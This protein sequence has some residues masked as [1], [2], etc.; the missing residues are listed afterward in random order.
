MNNCVVKRLLSVFLCA[1]LLAQPLTMSAGAWYW[2]VEDS[3]DR[4]EEVFIQDEAAPLANTLDVQ[5]HSGTA[6][7]PAGS[8]L[9]FV[10]Q[11]LAEALID[12]D[13]DGSA[14]DWEYYCEGKAALSWGNR[15]WGSIAGFETKTGKVIKTTYTHPALADNDRDN[16]VFQV[17]LA[18]TTVEVT[19]TKLAEAPKQNA[20]LDLADGREVTIPL[21]ADGGT[22]FTALEQAIFDEVYQ[23]GDPALSLEDVEITRYAEETYLG[24]Q[25]SGYVPLSGGK[26]SGPLSAKRDAGPVSAGTYTMKFSFAG[27]DAYYAAEETVSVILADK[28]IPEGRIHLKEGPY[29]VTMTYQAD[30]TS[31]DYAAAEQAILDAV[32]DSTEPENIPVSV[33]YDARLTGLGSPDWKALN[34]GGAMD[35][36]FGIGTW[37]IRLS[38]EGTDAYT[39]ASEEVE[40]TVTGLSQAPISAP[41]TAGVSLTYREDL[42]VDYEALE[43]ALRAL[44]TSEEADLSAAS[45]EYYA[46]AKTGSVGD[47]GKAWVPVSGGTK[48]IVGV[49]VSYPGMT[50]GTWQVKLTLPASQ[51]YAE[52]SVEISVTVSD[53]DPAPYTLREPAGSVK[54]PLNEDLSVRY[55][56][57]EGM[58]FDA[59]VETSEVLSAD[60][61]TIEYYASAKTGSVGGLGKA[62]APLAGG[63]VSGLDYPAVSAG[64]QKIRISWPGSQVYAPTVIEADV[65]ITDRDPVQF[66]LK[67]APYEVG[68]VFTAQQG[69]DYEATARAIYD[70]VVASTT[71]EVDYAACKVEY[72]VDLTGITNSFKPLDGTD[73]SGLVKFKDGKWKIRIS[74]G[75]TLEYR[76]SSVTVEVTVSDNRL[77]SAVVLKEGA[78]FTYNM[79]PAVMKQAVFEQVID[80]ENCTLPAREALSLDDFEIL[81]KAQIDVLDE[82]VDADKL[83]G[84]ISKLPGME[85]VGGDIASN[86]GESTK[87]FMPIEGGSY[88]GIPYAPMGAGK[89]QVQVSFKG[90]AEYRPSDAAETAVTVNKANVKVKVRSNNI[91]AGQPLPENFITTDPADKFEFYTIYA[92]AT[93]NVNLGIYLDLPDKFDNNKLIK[94][95]DPVVEKISGKSFSKMLQDGITLGE[96]RALFDSTELLELLEKVGVDTGAFGQILKVINALPSVTDGLRI[97]FGI[98]NRA[99][100]YT[101]TVIT[102]NKNYN[103]GVG[104]GALLVRMR[105]SGV[106]LS[107]NQSLGSKISAADAKSFDFKATLSHDGDVTIDQS[108]VHYLYSGFTSKWRV[109]SST[110]TPPTEPGRYTMTVVTLGGNYQAAPITRSFQITK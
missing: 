103:T 76:G 34:A 48:T 30:G 6:V 28:V 43:T 45:L 18:G 93:S 110:T 62:W 75:D 54:L 105:L 106:K 79:D 71:P 58:V 31:I 68:I 53:R 7:I 13:A 49:P 72:N 40:V 50:A 39:A 61:V 70:A 89:H 87:R 38:F 104:V 83:G 64:T 9:D 98:P 74:C 78:S 26:I 24:A 20:V 91:Y 1:L 32:V 19:L 5:L 36:K 108:N 47:A 35:K 80:W 81:Y 44:F 25:Y 59:V 23:G 8:S 107:W 17:R 63:K 69:Y 99:G 46:T 2:A 85:N 4:E 95:V 33:R 52:T 88:L 42:S 67:D 56:A 27:N 55:D 96:L 101:V 21:N 84:L 51:R 92:G 97:G 41:E 15:S 22:D 14:L 37:Q 66:T 3:L 29:T 109:Y 86:L 90:S 10:K 73:A 82:N 65:E 60:N 16:G 94:L 11:A 57:L 102:D 12:P 77:P 100:L